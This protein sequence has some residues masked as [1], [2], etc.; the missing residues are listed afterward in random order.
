MLQPASPPEHM[1]FLQLEGL[2]P[3]KGEGE[4]SCSRSG[5]PLTLTRFLFEHEPLLSLERERERGRGKIISNGISFSKL[6]NYYYRL[7]HSCVTIKKNYGKLDKLIL[8]SFDIVEN[9]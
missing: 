7:L 4:E 5:R 8:S 1:R 3:G 6:L 9:N 2:S